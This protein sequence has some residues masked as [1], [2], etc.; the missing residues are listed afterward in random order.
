MVAP[1][2]V[3]VVCYYVD[4]ETFFELWE[5]STLRDTKRAA[6]ITS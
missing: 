1:V 5:H 2:K 3:L 4:I 6:D